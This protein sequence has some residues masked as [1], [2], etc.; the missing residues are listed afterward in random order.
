M[1]LNNVD[2][3]KQYVLDDLNAEQGILAPGDEWTIVD[4]DTIEGKYGWIFNCQ[5]RKYIETHDSTFCVKGLGG[6]V[7]DRDGSIHLMNIQ[8]SRATRFRVYDAKHDPT[9]LKYLIA[10]IYELRDII[11]DYYN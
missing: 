7:A 2:Q 8:G 6:V 3:A 9:L 11:F 1:L 5:S 4:A 10:A